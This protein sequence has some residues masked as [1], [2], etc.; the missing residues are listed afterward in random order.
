MLLL[1]RDDVTVLLGLP[2][3]IAAVEQVFRQHARGE[4][5]LNPGVLGAHV[6][7]GGFH[8]KTAALAGS[9][10]Y[11]AA[12]VNANFPGNPAS[13]G[14]PTIQ[15]VLALFETESGRPLAMLDSSEI[16]AVRTAAATA[17]AARHLARAEA[18]T[19]TICGC[20][21]QG[22]TNLRALVQVRP[23]TRAF[24]LDQDLA[25]ACSFAEEL[26][27][28][29]GVSVTAVEDLVSAVSAS[30]I[31]VTCT[32]VRAPIFPARL[33]HPGLF[34]AAVGADSPDKQ[35]LEPAVLKQSRVVVDIL[36]Q[37]V[38][39]G[40]LHHAIAAGIMSATDIHA[41]LGQVVAGL[42]PGRTSADEMFVFDSTGTALQDVAA[43]A[44]V[45]ERA[46]GAGRGV[47]FA[48]T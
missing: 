34:L 15:G 12:K 8:I 33:L 28:E 4:L 25:R 35:E 44:L 40:D 30:D 39:M 22:R 3:C 23:I 14:L 38:T 9:P 7:G 16:T 29:L 11:F 43:A 47:Q 18:S 45:Y 5:P 46:L 17:V 26:G 27:P 19:V 41:T 42:R 32:P 20:G 31:C 37:A 24:A 2:D 10:G 48:L 6:P 21:S 13:V 1:N 36:E